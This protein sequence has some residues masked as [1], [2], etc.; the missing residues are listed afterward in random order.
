MPKIAIPKVDLPQMVQITD[1]TYPKYVGEKTLRVV[2]TLL[3]YKTEKFGWVL[4]TLPISKGKNGY[5]DRY[6]GIRLDGDSVVRVGKGPHVTQEVTIYVTDKSATRLQRYVGLHEA[7][8]GKAGS[9]RDRISSRRAQGVEMR[10][11]GRHFWR[12][13]A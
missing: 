3:F 10:A 9:I 2:K 7:G 5:G 8:L 13:D 6:Y 12:W 11:E 1:T 4:T